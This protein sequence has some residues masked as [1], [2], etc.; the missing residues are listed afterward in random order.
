[1]RKRKREIKSSLIHPLLKNGK[2]CIKKNNF[3]QSFV[4][5]DDDDDDDDIPSVQDTSEE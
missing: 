2:S 4:N 5:N 1:M 3:P